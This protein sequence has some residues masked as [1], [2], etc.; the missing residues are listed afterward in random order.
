M[1]QPYAFKLKDFI[2]S[3]EACVN[4]NPIQ[5]QQQI[6]NLFYSVL[7]SSVKRQHLLSCLKKHAG[8][9]F[10]SQ[11]G[12]YILKQSPQL[13]LSIFTLPAKMRT[14]VHNHGLWTTVA[15]LKGSSQC[16]FYKVDENSSIQESSSKLL[17][18]GAVYTL[19][20]KEPHDVYNPHDESTIELH[21]YPGDVLMPQIDAIRSLW[22]PLTLVQEAYTLERAVEISKEVSR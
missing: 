18:E 13:F 7:N 17:A 1:T 20:E 16:Q 10:P 21:F 2:A 12:A 4:T 22:H 19:D 11:Q 15:I 9:K 8:N 5:H 6:T 14:A 3:C